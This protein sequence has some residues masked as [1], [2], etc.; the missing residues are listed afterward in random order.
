[1]AIDVGEIEVV[2]FV[3]AEVAIRANLAIPVVFAVS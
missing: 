2:V 3:V 1:L